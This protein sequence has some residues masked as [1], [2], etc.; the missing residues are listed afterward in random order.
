MAA[1]INIE[2]TDI[3]DFIY[4]KPI[5]IWAKSS[6][7][8]IITFDIDNLSDSTLFKYAATLIEKE[9]K[10]VI[11]IEIKDE[12]GSVKFLGLAETIIK[13]QE[14]CAV[15]MKGE[16]KILQKMFSLLKRNFL[17]NLNEVETQSATK[18]FLC[19]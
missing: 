12:A 8:E 18:S 3:P 17:Q 13:N 14:K 11:Y 2:I 16:S 9:E 1:L 15:I 19:S 5:I 7:P 6:F 10:T 4:E